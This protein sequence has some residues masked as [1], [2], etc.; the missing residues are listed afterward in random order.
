MGDFFDALFDEEPKTVSGLMADSYGKAVRRRQFHHGMWFS[1]SMLARCRR[2]LYIR[3]RDQLTEVGVDS[4]ELEF[5]ADRGTAFHRMTQQRLGRLGVLFGGWRCSE[6]GHVHGIDPDDD[7]LLGNGLRR[8]VTVRSAVPIPLVC[9]GCGATTEQG[10][11][12]EYVEPTV[13][14]ESIRLAGRIDGIVFLNGQFIIIDV[15]TVGVFERLWRPRAF[16]FDEHVFQ[17]NLYMGLSGIRRAVILYEARAEEELSRFSFDAPLGF[18]QEMYDEQ[19]SFVRRLAAIGTTEAKAS[20]GVEA[21]TEVPCCQY[22]GRRS[23]GPCECSWLS[24]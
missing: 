17:V 19:C 10:Q 15:K 23:W 14:D 22:G 18:N 16:P 6:C 1:P 7:A 8:K 20:D 3:V 21:G 24:C 2:V 9:D 11:S 13:Y 4:P 12:F 5:A